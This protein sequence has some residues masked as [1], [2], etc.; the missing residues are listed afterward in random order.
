MSAKLLV[1]FVLAMLAARGTSTVFAGGPVEIRSGKLMLAFASDGR[2]KSLKGPEADKELLNEQDPGA[3]FELKGFDFD[4]GSP[5]SFPLKDLAFDG[6]QLSASIGDKVRIAFEVKATDRYIA[7]K[8][9]RVEGVPKSNLLW[10]HF[11]MNVQGNVKTLPLDYMTRTSAWGCEISWPWIWSRHENSI[12]GGFAI[13]APANDADEDETL[14]H[15]W[16][17]EGL[18]HPKTRGPWNVETA[19]KWLADWQNQFSDQSTMLIT[20]KTN[21]DLYALADFAAKMD[22]KRIYM[23]TDTWRGEYWPKQYSFLHLNPLVFP[24]GEEDF[25]KFAKFAQEKGMGV[26]I[27]T[28]SCAIADHDPDYVVGKM[29]PRLAKWIEGTLA[30]PVSESDK[31]I[32]FKPAPDAELPLNLDRPI[33]GPAHVD[34]WN[35][36]RTLRIG[37]EFIAVGRFADTDKPVWTLKECTRGFLDTKA[38]SHGAKTPTTGLIRPY[39]QCFTADN[40]STLVEELGGR[41]AEFCNRNNIIHCEQDAGEIHTVNHPWGY[42][43]F[44]EAVYT[45]LDHPV[46]SNNSGGSPMPCQFEY[47]FHSSKTAIAARNQPL[48]PLM[49]ARNGRLSTGPYEMF[50]LLARPIASGVKSIGIQ[51]PEPMF[52]VSTEIL[53]NHGLASNAAD[54][55]LAWKKVA[56][57]LNEQ[58]RKTILASGDEVIYRAAKTNCGYEVVPLR[59]LYRPKIDIG[60]K[61]GSEF[62]PIVPRQYIKTG[63]SLHVQNPYADQEPEFVVR[64]MSGFNEQVGETTEDRRRV[65]GSDSKDKEMV[66]AYNIGAGLKPA[67]S[68]PAAAS[69]RPQQTLLQPK[70]ENI[71][72]IGDHQFSQAGEALRIQYDNKRNEAVANDDN[73]PFFDCSSNVN[74]SEARGIG[75]TVTGDGSGAVLV[76]QVHC[77]GPRDYVVP[78]DFRGTREIIIPCGE[79]S[80]TDARWGWRFAT[81]GSGYGTLGRIALGLGKVPPK[82]HVDITVAK[83]RVLPEIP[84]ALKNPVINMGGGA[85]QINGSI[86][87]ESYAWYQGG[88]TIGVYDRNWNKTAELPVKKRSFTAPHGPLPIWVESKD[89]DPAP[90][91]ECQFFVKDTLMIVTTDDRHREIQSAGSP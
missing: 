90:W 65:S 59:M 27:H 57:L 22:I 33:T 39:N 53:D 15:I 44:A 49:I 70:A 58:Q 5:V 4:E 68:S 40:D 91:L 42:A 88:D 25:Q 9:S 30:R 16:A 21:Q 62:G 23:H 71:L 10:L 60:W 35:D 81:K 72:N 19:R 32:Y 46:T 6:K 18:P 54:T 85:M 3:G 80:W 14:L 11:K 78:L 28:V 31:T 2:P 55:V 34:P 13:Y 48:V 61:S 77:S 67:R 45:H 83:I 89:S 37:D 7:F 84:T 75:L 47:R 56:R 73:L 20:A 82:A 63:E 17:E 86:P 64:V 12:L 76:M 43:R 24:K 51:K 74:M 36:I 69:P 41:I 26:T 8:T 79:V 50:S 1:P 52:G 87:S 29:D 38:A 66:D